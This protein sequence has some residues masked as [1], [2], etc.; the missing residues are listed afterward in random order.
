VLLVGLTPLLIGNL[1]YI[2]LVLLLT[3]EPVASFYFGYC[4]LNWIGDTWRLGLGEM[5]FI[6]LARLRCSPSKKDF[7]TE[8]VGLFLFAM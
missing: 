8:F 7:Y 2:W 4:L 6:L 3:N 1:L 5:C